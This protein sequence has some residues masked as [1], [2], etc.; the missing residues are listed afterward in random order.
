MMHFYNFPRI[1]VALYFTYFESVEAL[2]E[3]E[4][5]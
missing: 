5:V 3:Q 2:V 1:T 4:F